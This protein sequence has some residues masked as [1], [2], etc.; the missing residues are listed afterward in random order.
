MAA[1]ANEE[2]NERSL[3]L[4]HSNSCQ[5]RPVTIVCSITSFTRNTQ[6]FNRAW[7]EDV[8]HIIDSSYRVM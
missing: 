2:E 1:A 6:D 8:C 5:N 7:P 4:S 3:L